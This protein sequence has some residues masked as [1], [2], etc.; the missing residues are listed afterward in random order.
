MGGRVGGVMQGWM[1]RVWMM[2][3]WMMPRCHSCAKHASTRHLFREGPAR[4]KQVEEERVPPPPPSFTQCR[5]TPKSARTFSVK[6][7]LESSRSRKS[8]PMQ[9]STF[10]T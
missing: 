5:P 2:R 7:P 4:V 1:M 8:A 10:N 6:A 9:P 3:V